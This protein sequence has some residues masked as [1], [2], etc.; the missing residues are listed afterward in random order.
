MLLLTG[1][2][3]LDLG[4]SPGA[5]LQVACKYLGPKTKGGMVLGID[6]QVCDYAS[7]KQSA[8]SALSSH[9]YDTVWAMAAVGSAA[10]SHY[11]SPCHIIQ[12]TWQDVVLPKEHCDSRV[13][14]IQA[15]ARELDI[16]ELFARSQARHKSNARRQHQ[17]HV[18]T[19]TSC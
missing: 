13:E 16:R 19:C 4:C 5:W 10:L 12:C 8:L 6:I 15:D 14:I 9:H 3:V 1:S 17:K 2:R 7:S 11:V 18:C